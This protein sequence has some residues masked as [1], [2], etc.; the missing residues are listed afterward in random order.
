MAFLTSAKS[1][2]LDIAR[3]RVT[4]DAMLRA[5]PELALA[6]V[7]QFA[8]QHLQ[9][10]D[11]DRLLSDD[12]V[13]DLL[14][15]M[16]GGDECRARMGS[17]GWESFCNRCREDLSF[18]VGGEHGSEADVVRGFQLGADDYILKPFSPVELSARVWRLLRRGRSASAV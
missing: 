7:G 2:G 1:L 3:N 12:V 18:D 10:D 8:G 4:R 17:N 13:R 6:P 11:F 14:R 16:G 15:W 9:A 5:L